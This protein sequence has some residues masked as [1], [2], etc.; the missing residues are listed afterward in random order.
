MQF[1]AEVRW[2]WQATAPPEV[3][4]WFRSG[5]FPPGGGLLRT[6]Q[7]LNNGPTDLGIKYRGGKQGVEIKGLLFI[8]PVVEKIGSRD[9]KVELWAKWTL[10]SLS[11][12]PS[13]LVRVRKTRFLRKVEI[14]GGRCREL[15]LDEHERIVESNQEVPAEGCNIE[16]TRINC[17]ECRL[18]WVTLGFE[19]FGSGTLTAERNLRL[20]L[21]LLCQPHLPNIT[22]GIELSYPAWIAQELDTRGG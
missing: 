11:L 22:G 15:R 2:F 10:Q 5:E 13:S 8:S 12:D 19:A 6:D 9:V 17:D 16:L 21:A 1:S 14:K 3:D 4:A 18:P 7:Y 20:T